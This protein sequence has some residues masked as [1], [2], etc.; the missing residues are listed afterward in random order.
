MAWPAGIRP[1]GPTRPDPTPPMGGRGP[2][3]IARGGGGARGPP[4]EVNDKAVIKRCDNVGMGSLTVT[5]D[6]AWNVLKGCAIAALDAKGEDSLMAR[7]RYA[8][9]MLK[10]MSG[11][12][13]PFDEARVV[14]FLLLYSGKMKYTAAADK[15]GISKADLVTAFDLW[16]EA[17][18]VFEYVRERNEKIRQLDNEELVEDARVGLSRL[19]TVEDCKLSTKAVLTTLERL[20]KKSFGD[21]RI[22]L[23]DDEAR[24]ASGPGGITVNIIGDAAKVCSTPPEVPTGKAAVFIDV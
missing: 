4:Y 16:P 8:L 13:V 3:S 1:T 2:P 15:A 11:D 7:R 14:K 5:D 22:K 6:S 18:T 10:K 9:K 17:R 20:D 12:V 21:P 19:I 24:K 23:D